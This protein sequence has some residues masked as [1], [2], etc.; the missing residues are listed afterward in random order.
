MGQDEA[1]PRRGDHPFL[2]RSRAGS[3]AGPGPV[4]AGWAD[5]RRCCMTAGAAEEGVR[6]GP[7]VDSEA[8]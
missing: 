6:P 2:P 4:R 5:G 3:A 8:A 7:V 1:R